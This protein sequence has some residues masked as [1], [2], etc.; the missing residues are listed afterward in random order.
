[1]LASLAEDASLLL[2][3]AVPDDV[4]IWTDNKMFMIV[5]NGHALDVPRLVERNESAR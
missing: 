2:R 5:Q 3:T 1:V 4:F